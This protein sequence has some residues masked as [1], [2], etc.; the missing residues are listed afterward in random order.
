MG[1]RDL[2]LENDL[3]RSLEAPLDEPPPLADNGEP[4]RERAEPLADRECERDLVADLLRE[5]DLPRLEVAVVVV[6]DLLWCPPLLLDLGDLDC[7]RDGECE[8][9]R[10]LLVTGE[11]EGEPRLLVATGLLDLLRESPLAI[12]SL[13]FIQ[14]DSPSCD[15]NLVLCNF[16]IAYR[17][18]S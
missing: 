14:E 7:E 16:L 12:S 15:L 4:L 6:V 13:N 11:Y 1:E 9:P 3:E 2:D 18:S 8:S 5:P 17:M 10:A